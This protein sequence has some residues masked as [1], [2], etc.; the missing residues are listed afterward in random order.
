M[1]PKKLNRPRTHEENRRIVCA[2]CLQKKGASVRP[3]KEDQEE[4]I[5]EL[6]TSFSVKKNHLPAGICDLCRRALSLVLKLQES[7]I[8][9]IMFWYRT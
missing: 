9:I 4:K 5:K 8:C 1:P 3:L 7:N 6:D 2:L